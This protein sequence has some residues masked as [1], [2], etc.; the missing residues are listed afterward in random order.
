MADLNVDGSCCGCET[1][2]KAAWPI[3]VG[4]VVL[5]D[6]CHCYRLANLLDGY[7]TH[8]DLV[9]GVLRE[10]E[11]AALEH[12]FDAIEVNHY[13]DDNEVLPQEGCENASEMG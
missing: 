3:L 10:L 11:F 5:D 1:E 4:R 8:E 7:V 2:E 12:H 9:D 6:R 13:P